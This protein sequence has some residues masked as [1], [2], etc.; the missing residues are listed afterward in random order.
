MREKD[1][2]GI[3]L[4]AD[5]VLFA[6]Q[7]LPNS[8]LRIGDAAE[9][10]W[11]DSCFDLVILST[12]LSSV[13]DKDVRGQSPTKHRRVLSRGG[14]VLWYDLAV[15]NPRNPDVNGINSIELKR[16]FP[17]FQISARSVTLAP[18]IARMTAGTSVLI[19]TALNSLPFLRTHLL[20]VLVRQ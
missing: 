6:Q 9:L 14:A 13:L 3:E 5:R 1:L 18:P 10:P 2:H 11:P 17:D 12:V 4:D 16:L 8:D 20:A 15:N 19:A 7:A